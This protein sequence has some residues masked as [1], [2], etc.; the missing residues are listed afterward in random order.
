[1]YR[2]LSKTGPA[3]PCERELSRS[4]DRAR[5]LDTMPFEN[6][7]GLTR[8]WIGRWKQWTIGNR[9]VLCGAVRTLCHQGQR[10]V[11]VS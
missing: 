5:L 9:E 2:A 11:R 10:T 1:M 4:N 3:P 8:G 7:S 6:Q